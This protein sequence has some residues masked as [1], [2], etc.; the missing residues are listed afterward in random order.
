MRAI[1]ADLGLNEKTLNEWV[2]KA[3]NAEIDPDGS[4]SDAARR[5]IRELRAEN[6]RLKKDLEF[7][8]KARAFI[9]EISRSRNASS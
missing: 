4:M 3:R 1:A 8:K 5:E 9:R 2:V 7:E 6:A